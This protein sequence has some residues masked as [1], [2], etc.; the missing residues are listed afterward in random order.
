[1]EYTVTTPVADLFV[2]DRAV[3][4]PLTVGASVWVTLADHGVT[5]V[6]S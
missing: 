4:H 5:I 1:M 3:A 6:P 2:V